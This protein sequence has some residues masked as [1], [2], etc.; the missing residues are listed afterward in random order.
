MNQPE[1]DESAAASPASEP[2]PADAAAR[3]FG[4]A[5]AAEVDYV[6]GARLKDYK[7]L[8]QIGAGGFGVV[9]MAEQERPIRRRVAI[10]IIKVGMDTEE[11]IARFEAE[12]QAVALMEHPNIARVFDAG[13]TDAG[14][15][16]F[17][18]ELVRG[19][20]ITRYCDENRL[21]AEARLRLF[22][23]V[24][25]AVQHAH[26]KG[27]IHRDLK[28]SNILVTLHDGVPV[29]KII[30]FG[31]A[32]ATATRLTEK[33]LFTQLH[34]F[35]GTPAY[36]SPEQMEM[37]GLD[38]D[39]RSDVY[40]LGI[41]LYELLAGRPPFE[42]E[43]LL[44]AGLEEMRRTIR[45]VD[46]IRPSRRVG[47]LSAELRT[48]VAQQ[49]GTDAAKLSL[50][51]RGDLDWIVMHCLEKDRTRRYATAASLADDV[52]RY[53]NDETVSARPPSAS[54][55]LHKFIRRHKVGF[56]AGAAV[57]F[58]LV[59]GL[60][61]SSVS[62][63]RAR[64][65][66]AKSAQVA[67]FMT[68]MLAS[69]GPSVALG[70]DTK[71]LREIL[72]ATALRL[73]TELRD[74]P[75]IA[76]ELRDTLGAVYADLG[77]Y[78]AAEPLLRAAVV[79]R[80]AVSGNKSADTS[81]SLHQL[82]RVLRRLQRTAEAEAALGEALA[83]RRALFGAAHPAYADT[84]YELALLPTASAPIAA[85]RAMLGEVLSIR[86]KVF[87]PEHP[88]VAEAINALGSLAQEELDHAKAAPLLSEALAM[89]RRL[90]GNEHP[91]VA[92][93]LD[94]LGYSLAHELD[95]KGD[96]A[97]VFGEAFAIRR[98]MLGDEHP[99]TLVS[100]LRFAGQLRAREATP[101]NVERVRGFVAAQRK[102][103]P[104]GSALLGPSLLALASLLDQPDR[105]PAEAKALAEEAR[106]VL[107][108][109]RIGGA[110]LEDGV[111]NAM[112]FF[113]WSKLIGNA[114]A[115][116]RSLGETAARLAHAYHRE[117]SRVATSATHILAW[118]YRGIERSDE[119]APQLETALR[120]GRPLWGKNHPMML[121]D[122]AALGACYRDL[123]RVAES[124][125]ILEDALTLYEAEFGRETGPPGSALILTDLG[126]TLIRESRFTE[127][128]A[129]LRRSLARYD[130]DEMKPLHL[131]LNPRARA[132]SGLGRALAGQ[133]KFAEAEPLVLQ[134]FQELKA[135]E[136]RLAGT[137]PAMIREARDAVL[138]L[139]RAWGRPEKLAEWTARA[140]AEPRD[141]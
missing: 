39:T 95:R 17:V 36:T 127:A 12:R 136:P 55:R 60:V 61:A 26:Q 73:D 117:P 87:G 76:A 11:V 30:D 80:R 24:C 132:A 74:Q 22:I 41:L 131:R 67:R 141:E 133:G 120:L 64:A 116:G 119:A 78:A 109:A 43:D 66:A 51:L 110:P 5:L 21:P 15:P 114:P 111:I 89:R 20:A 8:Q 121:L 50:L 86:K 31:I 29:S 40:S 69:V 135:R 77:Q 25:Q 129:V 34:A 88:A 49:R 68:D 125:R 108:E 54:D 91:L 16:F 59:A 18:M 9:W 72:D 123:D 82:G 57:A 10:K 102:L 84:V 56:A 70:R 27:V 62:L 1:F 2:L 13:A 23:T 7:L 96:A 81:A 126:L 4:F 3:A 139:Y 58:S 113:A 6:P 115:E 75:V 44:K 100:L 122:A 103:L 138:A 45:E 94:S 37:S 93:S 28:P 101:E 130:H 38:V 83:I 71:L 118:V 19:V 106:A 112:S 46:P 42:P 48:S 92:A 47:T 53:L 79:A 63:V 65:A 105:R 52:G 97:V 137:A 134:A 35:I 128:E 85:R 14:R 98:Q 140:D 99:Q 90:L 124:R 104:P 107:A 33:T 32:K